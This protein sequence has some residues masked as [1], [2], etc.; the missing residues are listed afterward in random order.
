[1]EKNIFNVIKLQKTNGVKAFAHYDRCIKL[2]GVFIFNSLTG[3]TQFIN[4]FTN[5]DEADNLIKLIKNNPSNYVNEDG[6]Y[7]AEIRIILEA[8]PCYYDCI[9]A[10]EY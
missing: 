10:I 4:K 3:K 8:G 9:P 7:K 1:M 5:I 6:E 2:Y